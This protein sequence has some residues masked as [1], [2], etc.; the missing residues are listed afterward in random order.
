MRSRSLALA[1]V[2]FG[3]VLGGAVFLFADAGSHSSVEAAGAPAAS[4]DAT[5]TTSADGHD[6]GTT[7]ASGLT[8][9]TPC[10]LS[11]PPASEGTL[12]K[13]E[14]H[15]ERGPS[16]QKPL[17]EEERILLAEQQAQAR[18]VALEFPTVATAEA[19]GYKQSTV[20]VPCIGAHYT[21]SRY[22]GG[23]DPAHPSELLFD[24]TAPDSKIV[25]L[26]YLVFSPSGAPEGFAGPNDYW[27]THSANG[28]LCIKDGIVVGSEAVD[29][30]EC[31][32]RGGR[33]VGLKG[34]YMVHDW[35]V[36]GWECS[37][38]VF[39][40]ECPELGGTAGKDAFS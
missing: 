32:A 28:G 30:A 10:E 21:N 38:G 14:G 36:P 20:Y 24:G 5:D 17:T 33:K 26:S 8:G 37:W 4:S 29:E 7:D 23:F 9:D 18:A 13:G 1:L 2:L 12:D 34:V 19:A 27:H 25:G 40:G 15:N 35:V 39:A 16:P 3:F 11:G 6:H 22:A 31:A